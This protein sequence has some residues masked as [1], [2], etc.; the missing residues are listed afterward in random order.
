M[1][2]TIHGTER[3][4]A[5]EK[6]SASRPKP[7]NP[8]QQLDLLLEDKSQLQGPWRRGLAAWLN[9]QPVVPP[10]H[11]SRSAKAV[12]L[13]TLAWVDQ[14]LNRYEQS[15]QGTVGI[16]A[17]D[18]KGSMSVPAGCCAWDG[19]VELSDEPSRSQTAHTRH[20]AVWICLVKE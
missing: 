20:T 5:H 12:I 2:S 9:L 1:R 8:G 10:S 3:F 14:S 18:V 16:D 15:R 11:I 6:D 13:N 7:L 17:G 4:P 19:I